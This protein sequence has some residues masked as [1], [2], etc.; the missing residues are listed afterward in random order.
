MHRAGTQAIAELPDLLEEG[1][2]AFYWD[3]FR[4]ARNI[5]SVYTNTFDC[6]RVAAEDRSSV[7]RWVAEVDRDSARFQSAAEEAGLARGLSH[8]DYRPANIRTA[9]TSR[10]C[11]TG[12]SRVPTLRSMTLLSRRFSSAAASACSM[13]C[14]WNSLTCSCGHTQSRRALRVAVGTCGVRAVDLPGD[15]PEAATTQLARRE[16]DATATVG[17]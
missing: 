4:F 11:W 9:G 12:T 6:A 13:T 7:S 10:R 5:R 14:R 3:V 8:Q 15:H 2:G 1:L 16:P 17:R